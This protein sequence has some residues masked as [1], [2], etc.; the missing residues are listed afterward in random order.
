[1][2]CEIMVKLLKQITFRSPNKK[3]TIQHPSHIFEV[4]THANLFVSTYFK[5]F[6]YVSVTKHD[7]TTTANL[8]PNLWILFLKFLT[9]LQY[10]YL[11]NY[12]TM[13][14]ILYLFKFGFHLN[15][16]LCIIIRENTFLFTYLLLTECA[17]RLCPTNKCNI[18]LQRN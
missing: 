5:Y 15:Y 13:V 16:I 11:L 2:L 8:L 7:P 1:M 12:K 9:L 4:F 6:S 18:Y 10:V 17:N 3:V 14:L